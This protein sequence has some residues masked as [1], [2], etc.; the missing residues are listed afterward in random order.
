[1]LTQLPVN[2]LLHCFRTTFFAWC[3]MLLA[4]V[5]VLHISLCASFFLAIASFTSSFQHHVS[6][7]IVFL[8]LPNLLSFNRFLSH[9]L[10]HPSSSS[11]PDPWPPACAEAHPGWPS[12]LSD[13]FYFPYP[14]E[15]SQSLSHF[16]L[17]CTSLS[18]S[19]LFWTMCLPHT[20]PFHHKILPFF[21]PHFSPQFHFLHA[22]PHL[23]SIRLPIC[24]LKSPISN[25][26]SLELWNPTYSSNH[27]KNAL[28]LHPFCHFVEHTHIILTNSS[29][30][31][32]TTVITLLLFFCTSTTIL[33]SS[34]LQNSHISRTFIIPRPTKLIS[35]ILHTHKPH[36]LSSPLHFSQTTNIHPPFPQLLTNL[37]S[38]SQS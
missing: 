38:R 21:L 2:S 37:H 7:C 18:Y 4:S 14:P 12:H 30:S 9:H 3:F 26:S 31:A 20:T 29:S 34:F 28:S 17:C 11:L 32:I 35:P 13:T 24:P 15:Q 6:P 25:T 16:P 8:Q 23:P 1:M 27:H 10:L 19:T 36:S 33:H 5:P 22:H